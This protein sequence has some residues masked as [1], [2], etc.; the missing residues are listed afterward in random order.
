MKHGGNVNL[1]WNGL[2][3]LEISILFNQFDCID[4]ILLS[5]SLISIENFSFFKMKKLTN[6]TLKSLIK[7]STMFDNI[8]DNGKYI[9]LFYI[10]LILNLI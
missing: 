7:L 10:N 4:C 6:N 8:L 3:I 1:K 5:P 2:N 9:F